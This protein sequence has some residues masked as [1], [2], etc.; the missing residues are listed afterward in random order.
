MICPEA[1]RR[2]VAPGRREEKSLN[3]CYKTEYPLTAYIKPCL[4]SFYH[5][6][7]RIASKRKTPDGGQMSL[8]K[9]N[10]ENLFADPVFDYIIT[11]NALIIKISVSADLDDS[12]KR[13]LVFSVDAV[14][15]VV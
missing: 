6:P 7:L 8:S 9:M 15:A 5:I 1:L 2:A 4:Y 13:R 14:A 10:F 3:L 12:V 11:H